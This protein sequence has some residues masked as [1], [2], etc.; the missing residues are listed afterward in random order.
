MIIWKGWGILALLIPLILSWSIQ[1]LAD[2][3]FGHDFYK[4]STWAM[5]CVF[6]FSSFFVFLI[7]DKLNKK[8]GRILI[9]PKTHENVEIKTSHTFFFIP[10]QYWGILWIGVGL[11]MYASNI[12]FIYG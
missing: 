12:G 4:T 11:W 1:F 5:P 2:S 3:V 8:Q 6:I 7:G 9:D 10:M